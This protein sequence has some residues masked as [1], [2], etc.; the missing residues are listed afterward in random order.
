MRYLIDTNILIKVTNDIDSLSDNVRVAIENYEN[1]IFVSSASV[2]EYIH[3]L[4]NGKVLPNK[5]LRTLN[6][7]DMIKNK[8]GFQIKYIAEEHLQTFAKLEVIEGHNDP[9]DRLII[10]QA[11]TEKIPLISSDKKF[12]K[13]RKQGLELIVNN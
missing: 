12:P 7:F 4:R 8:L 6:V 1:I 10:A 3:L 13:Y 11:I 9:N 2:T 5:E